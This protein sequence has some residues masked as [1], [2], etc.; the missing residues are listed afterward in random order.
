[1]SSPERKPADPVEAQ[2][3]FHLWPV[4]HDRPRAKGGRTRQAWVAT[5]ARLLVAEPFDRLTFAALG[6]SAG[7]AHGTFRVRFEN[8]NAIS[9]GVL[10]LL[11]DRRKQ[12]RQA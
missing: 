8:L 4:A 10:G 6:K 1:M 5:C 11:T 12:G 3:D 2:R 7:M 9:A